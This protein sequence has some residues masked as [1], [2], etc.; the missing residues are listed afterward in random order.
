MS[1]FQSE[2]ERRSDLWLDAIRKSAM[3]AARKLEE[4]VGRENMPALG[5]VRA[6]LPGTQQ[7]KETLGLM[8]GRAVPQMDKEREAVMNLNSAFLGAQGALR[9]FVAQHEAANASMQRFEEGMGR[10]IAQA[11]AYGKSI[12]QAAMEAAR[13]TVESIAAKALV[14]AIYATALGFLDLAEYNFGAAAQAFEA[15]AI[16]GAVGAAAATVGA[17]IPAG[18]GHRPP[19]GGRSSYYSSEGRPA[20]GYEAQG[21]GGGMGSA[22]APGAQPA[23]QPSGG[24]TVAIMGN[25]E[26]GQWLATTLNKAVMQQGVQLVSSGS[27]R[28]GHVGH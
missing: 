15:A 25:E 27:Q 26:A 14:E 24:L 3:Q 16:F 5:S 1:N 2:Q 17:V 28:G 6:G 22:L 13:A 8:G 12:R 10:N 19:S 21:P 9:Q 20:G 7:A 23:A 4:A 11:A 18:I